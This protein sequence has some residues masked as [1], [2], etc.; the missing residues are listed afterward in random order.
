MSVKVESMGC[1]KIKMRVYLEWSVFVV[2]HF[3]WDLTTEMIYVLL[4]LMLRFNDMR[5]LY[6]FPSPESF[7]FGTLHRTLSIYQV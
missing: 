2:F 4:H 3:G 6:S 5:I 1:E 7:I